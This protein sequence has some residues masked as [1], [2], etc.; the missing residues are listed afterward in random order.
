MKN[1]LSKLSQLSK[2]VLLASLVGVVLTLLSTIFIIFD[3]WDWTVGVLIGSA[4]EVICIVTLYAGVDYFTK[5]QNY[6]YFALFYLIRIILFAGGIV[7]AAC[8]TYVAHIKAINVFGVLIGYTPMQ[9]V[10]IMVAIKEKHL[11]TSQPK[12]QLDEVDKNGNQ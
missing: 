3:M 4:I 2:M 12:K 8:L 1:W 10:V 11:P 7:L 5:E 6:T 9:F